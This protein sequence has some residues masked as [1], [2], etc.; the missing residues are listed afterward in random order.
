M[1][2]VVPNKRDII[3]RYVRDI[4][5]KMFCGVS[6]VSPLLNY[7]TQESKFI[8]KTNSKRQ[9]KIKKLIASCTT[10][11]RKSTFNSGVCTALIIADLPL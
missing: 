2:N 6:D 7:I 11:F 9:K 1:P 3:I 10:T 5:E 4:P 8:K